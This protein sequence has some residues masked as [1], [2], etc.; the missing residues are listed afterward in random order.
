V[1]EGHS[2]MSKGKKYNYK[3]QKNNNKKRKNLI[4][5]SLLGKKGM[6]VDVETAWRR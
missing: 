2:K 6:V 3:N 1:K 4:F 5:S